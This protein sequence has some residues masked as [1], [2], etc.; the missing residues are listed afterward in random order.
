MVDFLTNHLPYLSSCLISA[1]LS[2]TVV[3]PDI[4]HIGAPLQVLGDGVKIYKE[5]REQKH[6]NG[7]NWTHKRG[8]L[9]QNTRIMLKDVL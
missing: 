8:H 5:A 7:G 2:L 9:G 4:R 1:Y 6:W 3:S